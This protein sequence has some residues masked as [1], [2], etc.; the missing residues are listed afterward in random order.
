MGEFVGIDPSRAHDLIRRL[1]ASSMLMDG[2]RPLMDAA[3]AEAGDDW[4]GPRHGAAAVARAQ[5]FLRDARRELRWR[6]DTVEQSVPVRERGLLT[7]VFPFAGEAEATRA[8]GGTATAVLAALATG[9]HD[10]VERALTAPAAGTPDSTT[11]GTTDGT[12][13]GTTGEPA[14]AAAFAAAGDPAYAAA[15]LGALGP[16]G[17]VLVLR[18]W[19]EAEV[20]GE[21]DGLP[22]AALARAADASPGLLARAFA[23]AERTGR[24]GEEWRELPATAPAD[25]L[26]TLIALARP[27]GAFLDAVAVELL[28]RRPDAGPDWNLHHLA[29]AYRVFPE[30]LQEL[31]AERPKETGVLLD[32]YAL[33]THPAY[34]RALAGALRHALEPGAGAD[35][36]RERAWSCLTGALDPEHR[37]WPALDA[38]PNGTTVRDETVQKAGHPV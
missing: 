31:L 36:L 11:R 8:A 1:E 37:L 24:L 4:A 22:P 16:D 14:H 10:E 33:G 38:V 5:A 23:G 13:D 29:A 34:E 35:G 25:V 9:R 27:S 19:S 30:A 6:V 20:P 12:T 18:G 26:T 7:A 3:V 2:V 28:N 32:A 15:L 17:L 21:R